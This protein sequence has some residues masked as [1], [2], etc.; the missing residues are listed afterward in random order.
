MKLAAL[1]ALSLLALSMGAMASVDFHGQA[2]LEQQ[3]TLTNGKNGCVHNFNPGAHSMRFSL[4]DS[5]KVTIEIDN[6][7]KK[8]SDFKLDGA[9]SILKKFP[10]NGPYN[11]AF[12]STMMAEKGN[13]HLK[14]SGQMTTDVQYGDEVETFMTCSEWG[15][16]LD[17]VCL[18]SRENERYEFRNV[19]S[20]QTLRQH[21]RDDERVCTVRALLPGDYLIID[22]LYR[23]HVEMDATIMNLSGVTLAKFQGNAQE[24]ETRRIYTG[25]CVT[26]AD[27]EIRRRRHH[28]HDGYRSRRINRRSIR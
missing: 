24:D 8:K 14:V 18:A 2:Q 22:Q 3:L 12:T 16:I 27:L 25:P 1:S 10:E 20:N 15:Y 28:E 26:E 11:G 23:Q 6:E 19:W 17:K 5:K 13:G 7:D 9:N 4:K 21:K